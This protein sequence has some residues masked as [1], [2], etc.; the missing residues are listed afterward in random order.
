[1]KNKKKKKAKSRLPLFICLWGCSLW[2]FDIKLLSKKREKAKKKYINEC[3]I[4]NAF[5]MKYFHAVYVLFMKCFPLFLSG[6][7]IQNKSF[8]RYSWLD[9]LI[10]STMELRRTST[11]NLSFPLTSRCDCWMWLLDVILWNGLAFKFNDTKR[12]RQTVLIANL[13]REV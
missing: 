2:A 3:I 9:A 12:N 13:K 10:F 4:H 11:T 6:K 8:K 1:M 5:K 7:K